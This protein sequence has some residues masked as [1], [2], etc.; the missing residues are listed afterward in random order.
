MRPAWRLGINSLSERR[1]RSA[2]LV[3]TVA[4]SALLI[5]AV[6][7]AIHSLHEGIRDRVTSTVG[8]A[9]LRLQHIG[10]K[11]FDAGAID[12]IEGWP[13][14][15]FAVGR[16]QDAIRLRNPRNGEEFSPTGFGVQPEREYRIRKPA[17][18]AGREL[19]AA[20]EIMIDM[21]VAKALD[22]GVG[23]TLEVVLFADT[24]RL[25][26]VGVTKAA[27]LAG[28][29]RPEVAVTLEQ[30]GDI[31]EW[32]GK[33]REVDVVLK[34]GTDPAAVAEAHADDFEKGL[35]LRTAKKITSG[36]DKSIQSSEIGMV[37]VSA[38]A[39]FAASFIIMTGMTTSV[40]ERQREL[41]VVRC[42][43]GTR[44]QLAEAQLVIGGVIGLLGSLIGVP[45]G[46]LSAFIMVRMFP[47]QLPAG[48]AWSWGGVAI[49]F[50]GALGAGIV[51]G[52]WPAY[53]AARTSPL[54]AMAV[55]A[56]KPRLRGILICLFAGLALAA[57]HVSILSFV[58]DVR[59]VVWGDVGIGM[60]SMFTGYFLLAV[61]VTLVVAWAGAPLVGRLLALPRGLLARTIAATPYRHGFTAAAMM[62]GLALLVA[63]WTNGR[64]VLNDWLD[65]MKFPDG[66]V[67]GRSFTEGTQRKIEAIPGVTGTC[68]I[69]IQ[70][71]NPKGVFFVPGL[72]QYDTTFIAFEPAKFF[73]MAQ[74]K[75]DEGDPATALARL[76][77]GGAILVAR[78]F[79]TARGLG[80]GDHLLLSAEG[81]EM[82]FEIVGVV[83]SPGLE[84]VNE[85]FDI[86]ERYMEQS[87]SAV[88]GSRRDLKEKFGNDAINLIQIA[89][90]PKA[91]DAE[92]IKQARRVGGVI[93]AGSGRQIKLDIAKFLEGS[94]LVFSVVAV[95]AML[96]A[97]FGVAN[98]I[99]AGIQARQ[100]EFGV[101]RAV[102]AQRGLLA[103]LV[104][105]EA[106]VIA[107]SACVLGTV[108]GMHAAWGGQ[109]MNG[110]LIG[111]TLES[112]RPP[113]GAT[114]AGWGVLTLITLAA[115]GPAAW[116]LARRQP[117]EL[118]AS[119]RG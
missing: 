21:G 87:I 78:E 20:G 54:E 39:F 28:L 30:L 58:K 66:F 91:D 117:R 94:L 24:L 6:N 97:C 37:V 27:P 96:V 65:Q 29:A 84:I 3:A 13:E 95:A 9:D 101:L 31:N 25:T 53:R 36:L 62:V 38:L 70:G 61:P 89:I 40:S 57:V 26:V 112:W 93:D 46:M 16:G 75:F 115:A 76:E 17:L 118:L 59:M 18:A 85:F 67:F 23:D 110:I 63:I 10:R 102:G 35:V 116:R 43:G 42:I 14:V 47:D 74:I 119:V 1:S 90:D 99:V 12:T 50:F 64:A 103:R 105:G 19:R 49:A 45:L 48:F 114:A 34:K 52:A 83:N 106:L 104:L 60:P 79:K 11:V 108:M 71:V 82:D 111:L 7:T 4:L 113:L 8:A 41:A 73:S 55:R 56:H 86:G 81:K 22:A 100:F 77:Q 109:K 72:Q 92:V 98:L 32:H 15:E 107:L 33:V 2:L 80:V 51:G 68:A 44:T 88:F 69:T 5:A